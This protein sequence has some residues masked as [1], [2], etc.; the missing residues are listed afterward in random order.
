MEKEKRKSSKWKIR[1]GDES[2]KDL[3]KGT[4]YIYNL[5][6]FSKGSLF[7][8][9]EKFIRNNTAT[10]EPHLCPLSLSRLP[11]LP[12]FRGFHHSLYLALKLKPHWFACCGS[13]LSNF[14]MFV[15]PFSFF[16]LPQVFPFASLSLSLCSLLSPCLLFCIAA[17]ILI[18]V[19]GF[20]MLLV[21]C[22][23]VSC[24]VIYLFMIFV[25]F[26][27]LTVVESREVE[28]RWLHKD[29]ACRRGC[30]NFYLARAP[31]VHLSNST[32]SLLVFFFCVFCF[33]LFFIL[34]EY[35][36]ALCIKIDHYTYCHAQLAISV[37]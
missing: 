10:R 20:L 4:D 24:I 23:I 36:H 1:K 8:I 3:C 26:L 33:L 25:L 9:I 28:V 34:H 14:R 2:G 16:L 11:F 15:F 31:L 21:C 19:L 6:F 5:F 27:F 30:G 35:F 22:P 17:M 13:A 18:W 37:A 7:R 29:Q 32:P 12:S